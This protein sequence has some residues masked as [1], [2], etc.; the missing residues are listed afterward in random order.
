MQ[1]SVSLHPMNEYIFVQR[2]I[3]ICLRTNSYEDPN[4]HYNTNLNSHM[5]PSVHTS[6]G[7][8]QL[9]SFQ[10]PQFTFALANQNRSKIGFL[11]AIKGGPEPSN[12]DDLCLVNVSVKYFSKLCFGNIKIQPEL[13]NLKTILEVFTFLFQRAKAVEHEFG[14]V[15][16][17]SSIFTG[18]K[19]ARI[20]RGI[21]YKYFEGV[22]CQGS[23]TVRGSVLL[24]RVVGSHP[25]GIPWF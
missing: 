18:S 7:L 20:C 5:H 17:I 16:S 25:I 4:Q 19:M 23:S 12:F 13:K 10:N 21:K 6:L 11:T 3:Q 1:F 24:Q 22:Q 9:I 2:S 15:P 14:R 8:L